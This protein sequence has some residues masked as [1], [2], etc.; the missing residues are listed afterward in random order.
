MAKP[1]RSV[2]DSATNREPERPEEGRD[3][4]EAVIEEYGGDYAD[5]AEY[6]DELENVIETA[7]LV[8]SSADD[9]EVDYVTESMVTLV[10]AG[11]AISNEGTVALAE[12]FGE[13][14][15][16]FA[17]LIDDVVRMQEEGHLSKFIR[18]AE[19][20]AEPLDEDDADRLATTV[21]EN[22]DELADVLD[23]LMELQKAGQLEDLLDLA[24]TLSVLEADETTANALNDL[25]GAV[26]EAE[27][28]SEPMGFLGALGALRSQEAR[29][30]IGYVVEILKGLGRRTT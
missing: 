7:I 21:G 3:A 9:E 26:G 16:E 24:S 5:A 25:L 15:D 29:A 11:D 17:D 28:E 19:T 2:P 10:Q 13:N 8:I 12:S 18:I 22:A 20:L 6:T 4:L 23:S 30:G 14:S 1:A 27:E